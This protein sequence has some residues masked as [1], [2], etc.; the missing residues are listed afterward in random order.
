MLKYNPLE[1]SHL[2]FCFF[3]LLLQQC[4]FW[5]LKYWSQNHDFHDFWQQCQSVARVL[6]LL[7]FLYPTSLWL[8]YKL[9]WL[10]DLSILLDF[11]LKQAS[12]SWS[13]QHILV[14]LCALFCVLIYAVAELKADRVWIMHTSTSCSCVQTCWS[15]GLSSS[16]W[17]HFFSEPLP[18]GSRKKAVWFCS[19]LQPLSRELPRASIIFFKLR[20]CLL[21]NYFSLF[22]AK[23]L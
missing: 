12:D 11:N 4:Y 21:G 10:W 1:S 9:I 3:F 2:V 8:Y 7:Q 14:L 5:M 20:K 13:L 17:T 15:E 16:S 23:L 22:W 19:S 18:S 6:W